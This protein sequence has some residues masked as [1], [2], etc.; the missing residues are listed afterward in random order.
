MRRSQDSEL[1]M[2]VQLADL[3]FSR[4]SEMLMG[5]TEP[6]SEQGTQGMRYEVIAWDLINGR[7]L[8]TLGNHT[9]VRPW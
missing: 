9:T 6:F 4:N 8:S 2:G 1:P 7:K 5:I 3:E